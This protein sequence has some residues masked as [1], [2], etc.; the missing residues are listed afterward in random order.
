MTVVAAYTYDGY[1]YLFGDLLLS[2]EREDKSSIE[3][4]ASGIHPDLKPDN[5]RISELRQKIVV[6]TPYCALGFAGDFENARKLFESLRSKARAPARLTYCEVV[7]EINAAS[8]SATKEGYGIAIVG[9]YRHA[10]GTCDSLHTNATY[11][12]NPSGGDMLVAGTG[13]DLFLQAFSW[14]IDQT[15]RY[16]TQCLTFDRRAHWLFLQ[17]FLVGNE[18]FLRRHSPALSRLF[19]GG[20]ELICLREEGFYKTDDVTVVLWEAFCSLTGRPKYAHS[21]FLAYKMSYVR[22]A[23]VIRVCSNAGKEVNGMQFP[24]RNTSYV[25]L[26]PYIDPLQ[27]FPDEIE[28]VQLDSQAVC[29]MVFVYLEDQFLGFFM[30]IDLGTQRGSC[31]TVAFTRPGAKGNKSL[32]CEISENRKQAFREEI[33]NT[34]T[35]QSEKEKPSPA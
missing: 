15:A 9:W 27:P 35:E 1:L 30:D 26:P 5:S 34:V 17:A 8:V 4:P 11:H 18:G 32:G 23:L 16:T 10:D 13:S 28:L 21:P 20:Y 33:L 7:A 19:G 14:V 24:A 3:L 6:I 29:H 31:E 12:K 25:A 2:D 22:D